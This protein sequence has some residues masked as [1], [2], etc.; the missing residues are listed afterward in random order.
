MVQWEN[1]ATTETLAEL[2]AYNEVEKYHKEHIQMR[3]TMSTSANDEDSEM[4]SAT[5][6]VKLSMRNP[7]ISAP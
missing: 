2:D 6:D 1:E 3:Q 7:F 4:N 5:P